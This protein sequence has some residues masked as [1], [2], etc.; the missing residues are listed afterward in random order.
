MD[1]VL[2]G[3]VTQERQAALVLEELPAVEQDW[4]VSGRVNTG[5]QPTTVHVRKWGKGDSPTGSGFAPS[6]E[7]RSERT[8]RSVEDGIPT[9]S[10][11]H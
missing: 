10:V 1:V 4:T 2:K 7:P 11:C 3:D 9:Q 5:N 6:L 8:T